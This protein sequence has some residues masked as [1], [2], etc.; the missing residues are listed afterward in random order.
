MQDSEYIETHLV[1]VPLQQTKEFMKSY[2]TISSWVV[3]RSAVKIDSD[4]DFTLYAVTTFKK[5]L[6]PWS[7]ERL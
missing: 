5:Y 7:I 4:D 6:S 1:A 3:P 2:E